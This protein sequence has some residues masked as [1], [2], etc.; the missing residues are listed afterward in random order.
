[1]LFELLK[2]KIQVKL[3]GPLRNERFSEKTIDFPAGTRVA[4]VLETLQIEKK[5][6]GLVLINGHHAKPDFSL[7]DGDKLS[8][9]PLLAGG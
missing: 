6:F 2:M 3:L 9:L 7:H 4:D 8:I 5:S 1:M